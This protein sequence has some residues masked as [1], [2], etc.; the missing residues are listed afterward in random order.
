MKYYINNYEVWLEKLENDEQIISSEES[1]PSK[2]YFFIRET[3]NKIIGMTHIRLALNKM[4]AD[5]GGI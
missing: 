4:L 5:I 3:D 1:F 2:T